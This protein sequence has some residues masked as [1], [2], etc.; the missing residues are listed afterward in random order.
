MLDKVTCVVGA[1]QTAGE[2]IGNGRAIAIRLA[3]EGSVLVLV[4]RDRDS[5][6][7]TEALIKERTDVSVQTIVVDILDDTSP[8]R[9]V[10]RC[11]DTFGRLDVLVNNVGI[12]YGDRSIVTFDDDVWDRIFAVNVKAMARICR[13][14][15]PVMRRQ[16]GG[17]IVNV[18][19]IASVLADT[20]NQI[21]YK[22][23]KAAV[24]ALTHAIAM[25]GAQHGIRANTVVLGLMD[26]PIAVEGFSA[27]LGMSR[28]ELRQMRDARVPLKGGMGT[29]ADTANAVLFLASDEAGFITGVNLAVDGGQ[30]ANIG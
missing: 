3:E 10:Q 28:G 27:V 9:I 1:G 17:A 15:L 24:H 19:S 22:T 6:E 5:L 25:S 8:Q 26:T 14:V 2:T 12:A 30:T 4:D 29:A 7:E 18:S 21:A 23:S 13:A 20:S 16:G 11:V